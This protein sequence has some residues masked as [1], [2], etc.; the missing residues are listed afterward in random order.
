[1][2]RRYFVLFTIFPRFSHRTIINCRHTENCI[3]FLDWRDVYNSRKIIEGGRGKR[4]DGSLGDRCARDVVNNAR[5]LRVVGARSAPSPFPRHTPPR[6]CSS[7][8]RAV[9]RVRIVASMP[10]RE[11]QLRSRERPNQSTHTRYPHDVI[12]SSAY[13]M[14][15][16]RNTRQ[17]EKALLAIFSLLLSLICKQFPPTFRR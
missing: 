10:E 17:T 6:Q 14:Y 12:H 2:T 16:L 3:I 13:T 15:V 7:P 8:A 9:S 11:T 1:M 4:V 5:R